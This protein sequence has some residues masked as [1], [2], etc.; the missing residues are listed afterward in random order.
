MPKSP[1]YKVVVTDFLNHAADAEERILGDIATIE[2]MLANHE[3]QLAGK[4]DD[5]DCVMIYHTLKF[6]ARSIERL[7]HCKLIVRCGVGYDNVDGAAARARGI[8]LAN[9][10]DYG[11]EEVADTAIGL[12]LALTRGI[13]LFN[14]VLRDP[15][16]DWSHVQASPVW[17]LRGRVFGIVGLGR[18]GSAAA[19]R[20]K[21]LGMDVAFYDPYCPDGRDKALGV[22]RVE[23]LVELLAKAHVLSV[24][25]PLTDETRHIINAVTIDCLP[26]GSF[27]VN[28][29]RGGVVDTSAIPEAI[30]SGRLAGAAIDVLSREPPPPD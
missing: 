1:S 8:A 14:S 4:I 24:H 16:A 3:E 11:T 20:A 27:L 26:Q 21:A 29:A 2:V 25:C 9:V 13:A 18:I 19:L 15:A 6:T 22:R 23:S 10:P 30:A 7:K 12:T 28:T 17:R 5:A